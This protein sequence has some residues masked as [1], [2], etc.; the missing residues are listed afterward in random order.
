M[1]ACSMEE[2]K[3][4]KIPCKCGVFFYSLHIRLRRDDLLFEV[5]SED[6]DADMFSSGEEEPCTHS[7]I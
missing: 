3:N 2:R 5:G 6:L 7:G 4:L 1:R